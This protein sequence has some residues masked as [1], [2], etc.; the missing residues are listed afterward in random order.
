MANPTNKGSLYMHAAVEHVHPVR[1]R[2]A[3]GGRDQDQI[4]TDLNRADI[5]TKI[6]SYKVYAR[7]RDLILNVRAS[8]A[9]V[10]RFV[11]S[12]WQVT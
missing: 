1:I 9:N 6:L 2:A 10:H 11:Q 8:A 5:L 4:A 12:E 7:M 3:A